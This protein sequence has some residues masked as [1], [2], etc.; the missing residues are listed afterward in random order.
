MVCVPDYPFK[1]DL[2]VG[3]TAGVQLSC[4]P[5]QPLTVTFRAAHVPVYVGLLDPAGGRRQV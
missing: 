3:P 1:R 5:S 2:D 4:T